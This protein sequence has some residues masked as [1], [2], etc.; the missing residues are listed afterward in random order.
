[1]QSPADSIDSAQ[2]STASPS[3]ARFGSGPLCPDG[4]VD[5]DPEQ[6][7]GLAGRHLAEQLLV[8]AL[9]YVAVEVGDPAALLG[10]AVD[11]VKPPVG[12]LQPLA[13]AAALE[14]VH[15]H[16]QGERL[17]GQHRPVQP[18]HLRAA[19]RVR[20]ED[21]LLD[22]VVDDD[23]LVRGAEV[24]ARLRDLL[25]Q[26]DRGLAGRVAVAGG[27]ELAE[28]LD[29]LARGAAA[30]VGLGRVEARPQQPHHLLAVEQAGGHS[31]GLEL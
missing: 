3:A 12:E 6:V 19:C 28:Q 13:L 20:D 30:L 16:R 11:R 10:A 14:P 24:K 31:L 4:L 2:K 23:V 15:E 18:P 29:R 1:M 21:R 8:L 25:L 7:R 5:R 9:L 17:A 26:P 27:V 22:V